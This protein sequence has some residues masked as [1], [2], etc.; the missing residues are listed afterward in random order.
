MVAS[1]KNAPPAPHDAA[2]A[3]RWSRQAPAS[4]RVLV[5]DDDEVMREFSAMIMGRL[6]L[7]VDTADDGE[8]GWKAICLS[9]YALV[10]TDHDMPRLTGLALIKRVRA[11][12]L[13]LP[14]I[15]V[16]GLLPWPEETLVQLIQPG[17]V[18]RKPFRP[19]VLV[20]RAESLL[21]T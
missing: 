2:V 10:V 3:A 8:T 21:M 12:S 15:L 14:C 20:A 4:N 19:E 5:V 6:G 18:L 11:A 1:L 17:A 9:S 7:Q 16:S 13:D